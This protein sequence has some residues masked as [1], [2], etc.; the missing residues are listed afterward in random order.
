M[1]VDIYICIDRILG[2][3]TAV[4]QFSVKSQVDHH[5][6]INRIGTANLGPAAE[7]L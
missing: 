5:F 2:Y 6:N 3:T 1:D 7:L 4:G